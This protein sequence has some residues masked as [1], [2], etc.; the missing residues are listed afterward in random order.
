MSLFAEEETDEGELSRQRTVNDI[1]QRFGKNAILKGMDL[2]PKAT[3][4]E[5]N[6]QIGGHRSGDEN[7]GVEDVWRR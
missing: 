2:M 3:A 5:R 7:D 4:R 6:S 1:R